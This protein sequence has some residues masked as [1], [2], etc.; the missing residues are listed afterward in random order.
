V[1]LLG[2]LEELGKESLKAEYFAWAWF[3]NQQSLR[4]TCLN[5]ATARLMMMMMMVEGGGQRVGK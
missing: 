5:N 1:A 4:C 3:N 2:G